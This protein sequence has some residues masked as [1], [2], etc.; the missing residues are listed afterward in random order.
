MSVEALPRV[1]QSESAYER[2]HAGLT[3]LY[4]LSGKRQRALVQYERL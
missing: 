3:Y 4:A 1:V 2:E